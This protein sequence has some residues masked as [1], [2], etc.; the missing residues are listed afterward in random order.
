MRDAVQCTGE[1]VVRTLVTNSAGESPAKSK[2]T[3]SWAVVPLCLLIVLS[4]VSQSDLVNVSFLNT[5]RLFILGF[6]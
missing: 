5:K 4:R 1:S 3:H 2:P 6:H